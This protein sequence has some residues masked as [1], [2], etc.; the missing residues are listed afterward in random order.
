MRENEHIYIARD[1]LL[2]DCSLIANR[3]LRGGAYNA[4]Q[5]SAA[6]TQKAT[7]HPSVCHACIQEIRFFHCARVRD[8]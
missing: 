2:P 5:D 6:H 7:T 8:C 4:K 3:D 1:L